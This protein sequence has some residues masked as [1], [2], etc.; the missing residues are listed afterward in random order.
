MIECMKANK[1]GTLYTFFDSSKRQQKIVGGGVIL[2]NIYPCKEGCLPLVSKCFSNTLRYCSKIF[3]KISIV[4]IIII[5][6]L[7]VPVVMVAQCRPAEFINK[8]FINLCP[9]LSTFVLHYQPLSFLINLWP[10]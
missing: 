2:D 7:C 6:L 10:L 5:I 9:S 3:R 4:F 1:A 8:S